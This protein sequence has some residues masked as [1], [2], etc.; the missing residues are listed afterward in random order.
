MED[1]KAREDEVKD[2]VTKKVRYEDKLS[3]NPKFDKLKSGVEK[4]EF[5]LELRPEGKKSVIIGKVSAQGEKSVKIAGGIAIIVVV[6]VFTYFFVQ[7][8]LK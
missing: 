7:L 8:Y 2:K 3:L 1:K 4:F 6:L 5:G